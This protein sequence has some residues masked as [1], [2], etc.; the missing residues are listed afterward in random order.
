MSI[1]I[2]DSSHPKYPFKEVSEH[3]K[4][5]CQFSRPVKNRLKVLSDQ[6]ETMEEMVVDI[7]EEVV[8][9][10]Q[11][12]ESIKSQFNSEFQHFVNEFGCGGSDL[13]VILRDDEFSTILTTFVN[14]ISSLSSKYSLKENITR[15]KY[16]FEVICDHCCGNEI[17]N[18]GDE[19]KKKKK[20]SN[21]NQEKE[22]EIN[23]EKWLNEETLPL[24]VA[25]ELLQLILDHE[26]SVFPHTD[27]QDMHLMFSQLEG[28]EIQLKYFFDQVLEKFTHHLTQRLSRFFQ[29]RECRGKINQIC[30][31]RRLLRED[32]AFDPCDVFQS[33]MYPTDKRVEVNEFIAKKEEDEKRIEEE[34][35]MREEE[36]ERVER[37]EEDFEKAEHLREELMR[38]MDEIDRMGGGKKNKKGKGKKGKRRRR[39]RN[40]NNEEDEEDEE[41]F[42][43]EK[44]EIEEID[45]FIPVGNPSH[46]VPEIEKHHKDVREVLADKIFHKRGERAVLAQY[47]YSIS[48]SQLQRLFRGAIGRLRIFQVFVSFVFWSILF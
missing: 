32:K 16:S 25:I 5:I 42:L 4:F 30:R 45:D 24:N 10:N 43:N 41:E 29:D 1:E 33:K 18:V 27:A 6:I 34:L 21:K 44:E 22:Y 23:R 9:L 19:G 26:T 35:K 47:F 12:L 39:R 40:K 17:S 48:T 15:W 36:I 3:F 28:S 46:P 13:E 14:N 7:D 2:F 31:E 11:H 38:R 20:K 37:E 8:V